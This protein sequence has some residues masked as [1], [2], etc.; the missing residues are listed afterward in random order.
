MGHHHHHHHLPSSADKLNRAFIIGILLNA[1]F[2]VVEFGVGIFYDSMGLLSDAGH[3]LSDVASLLLAML[4]FRLAQIHGSAHYTYG[5]RKSTI[6]V[7]LVNSLILMAAVAVII[8]ESFSR[9]FSPIAIEG[10]AVAWTAGVGIVINGVT[11]WLFMKDKDHDLNVKGAFLHMAA[12][13]LVSVGVLISGVLIHYTGLTWVDPVIGL[14]I[15]FMI[16]ASI[17]S[18][19]HDSLRL[20]LDGVPEGIDLHELEENL[21][22]MKHICGVHHI[23]VWALSTTEN[24]MT[25]HIVIEDI[26]LQH[27]VKEA[28]KEF[29]MTQ[30]ICHATLELEQKGEHCCNPTIE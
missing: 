2:V 10:G 6:L 26:L 12:D 25:A 16:L 18:L 30:N 21:L 17:W 19:L 4:G 11:A 3:N 9:L 23:H 29:L 28:V 24:A 14:A 22:K 13:T 27:E 8:Y 1:L 20:A 15:A 5:F 7:S